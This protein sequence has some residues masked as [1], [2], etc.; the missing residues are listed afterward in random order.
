MNQPTG[1]AV[2]SGA[3][4][5]FGGLLERIESRL[6]GYLRFRLGSGD[7]AEDLFQEAMLAAHSNWSEV[8][9]MEN[10]EAWVFRVAR[11]LAI[12]HGKRRG[13]ERRV[14]GALAPGVAPTASA[15]AEETE[16]QRRIQQA[17]AELPEPEREAVCLKIWAGSSWVEIARMLQVS[18]DTA[19]RLFARG[20]KAISPRLA[21]LAPGGQS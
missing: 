13:T 19:T 5:S 21:D 2:T 1:M 3:E 11:N 6:I 14:L 8:R 9:R 16:T 18:E 20:L 15:H 10:P 17:L 7:E 4:Q 12:N